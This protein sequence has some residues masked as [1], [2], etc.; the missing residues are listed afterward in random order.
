MPSTAIRSKLAF[1]VANASKDVGYYRQMVQ[2]AGGESIMSACADKGLKT[3]IEDGR[4]GDLIPQLVDFYTAQ[5][6]G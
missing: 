5:L 2:D 3:A 1:T 6:K 4:G